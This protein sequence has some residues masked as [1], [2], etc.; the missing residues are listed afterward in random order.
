MRWDGDGA[1]PASRHNQGTR[2]DMQ[3]L[4]RSHWVLGGKHPTPPWSRGSSSRER[5]VDPALCT[6]RPSLRAFTITKVSAR[7]DRPF[8]PMRCARPRSAVLAGLMAARGGARSFAVYSKTQRALRYAIR[9]PTAHSGTPQKRLDE[10][11]RGGVPWLQERS[12]DRQV[13]RCQVR[14]SSLGRWSRRQAW[15][16]GG[17]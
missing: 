13:V 7:T 2:A 14:E 5:L 10:P 4:L 17:H 11:A 12:L 16:A 1:E 9:R 8:G 6:P 3:G 15:G